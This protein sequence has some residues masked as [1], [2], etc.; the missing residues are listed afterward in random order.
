MSKRVWIVAGYAR[1]G[2]TYVTQ[3]L[4]QCE[5]VE[6]IKLNEG[7]HLHP[8]CSDHG[9]TQLASAWNGDEVMIVR[10]VRHPMDITRSWFAVW[11]EEGIDNGQYIAQSNLLRDTNICARNMDAQT[12]HDCIVDVP[13]EVLGDTKNRASLLE[14]LASNMSDPYNNNCVMKEHIRNTWRVPSEAVNEGALRYQRDNV[15]SDSEQR[16]WREYLIPAIELE[17]YN[18]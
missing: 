13:Y 4:N 17:G 9:L 6:A 2:T 8:Y 18:D 7:S 16:E 15:M 11:D 5:G 3:L 1:S 14:T 10:C 12:P